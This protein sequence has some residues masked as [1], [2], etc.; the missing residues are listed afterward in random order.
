MPVGNHGVK[1]PLAQDAQSRL[2]IID[3]G[4][5]T[6]KLFKFV[7]CEIEKDFIVID[8]KDFERADDADRLDAIHEGGL[9]SP[10]AGFSVRA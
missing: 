9:V 3:R 6:S 1:V 10:T 8:Q 4:Y 5:R 2:G 7:G